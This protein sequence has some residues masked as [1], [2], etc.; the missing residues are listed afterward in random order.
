MLNSG[1]IRLSILGLPVIES[2]EDFSRLTH[3]STL[4]IY[5]LSKHS[6]RHYRSYE[7]PKKNG[8]MR[9]ISQP[10]KNMKGIQA[11][12]L[13]NILNKLVSSTSSKG[14]ERKSSTLDNVIPHKNA[15][16]VLILDIKDFFPNI[17]REKVFNIFKS[18]GYNNLISTI[19]T[20]LCIYNNG[21]P[22]GGPCSPKLSNLSAWGLDARIQGYVGRRTITY[23]RYADDLTF[24]GQNV[25][26]LVKTISF[27]EKIINDEGLK[28]NYAKTRVAG[29]SR[30]K[31]ITGL[32]LS[33]DKIGIGKKNYKQLRAK[34]HHLTKD[35]DLSNIKPVYHINGWLAYLNSVDATRYKRICEYVR[36]LKERYPL[37]LVTLIHI[38]PLIV[39][40]TIVTRLIV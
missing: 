4:T 32:V 8:T 11:W 23:T 31:I 2:L 9:T 29:L 35:L 13:Y 28:L 30:A 25:I 27:L 33:E 20:S 38:P 24:S 18:A 37:K 7:I 22:Q 19:L 26:K 39:S 36:S 5:N 17:T 21:L 3:I 1:K 12:I 34:V 6:D 40:K 10:S 14:F 16:A 15:S